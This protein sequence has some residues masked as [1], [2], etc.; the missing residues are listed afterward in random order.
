MSTKSKLR[1]HVTCIFMIARVHVI[2]K[3]YYNVFTLFV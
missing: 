2:V 3:H 1:V